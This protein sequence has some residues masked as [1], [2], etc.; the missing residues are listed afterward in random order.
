MFRYFQSCFLFLAALALMAAAGPPSVGGK[1][2]DFALRTV[3]GKA[4]RLSDFTA[5]G[6]V[7]LTVLRGYPGYQCPFCNRQAQDFIRQ[8]DAF[9]QAGAHVVMVYP[10]P[11][12][13]LGV[14]A[15]EF[16]AGKTLPANFELVLDPGYGFTNQYGLRWDEY[17]ET[18]YP[19]T[20]L[21][22][23]DGMVFFTKSVKGHGGRATAAEI[24]DV[25]PKKKARS[26]TVEPST[27]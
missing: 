25:L 22:D 10:G 3:Q 21:I 2:P 13:D 14:R 19:S 18:A 24:L 8:S 26:R 9:A 12:Q 11:S 6:P 7:V 1:A 4:V 23:G 27:Q 20:F 16:M 5:K 15:A 17:G